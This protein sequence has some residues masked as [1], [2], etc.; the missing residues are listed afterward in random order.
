MVL[1]A[2]RADGDEQPGHTVFSQNAYIDR[3]RRQ[4][5]VHSVFPLDSS[6]PQEELIEVWA[7]R[8]SLDR[9]MLF[10][11]L[12]DR[13]DTKPG[14][15]ELLTLMSQPDDQGVQVRVAG[16]EEGVYGAGDTI[17]FLRGRHM[18]PSSPDQND[19]FEARPGQTSEWVISLPDE[20]V[21]EV[22]KRLKPEVPPAKAG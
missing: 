8:Y 17:F 5:R 7:G 6:T 4:G 21:K 13:A 14:R 9:L 18:K 1:T 15:C 12:P 10:R 22:E 3:L 19:H 2:K 20:T 16:G 11:S